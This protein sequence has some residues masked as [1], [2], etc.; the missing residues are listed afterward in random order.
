MF[1]TH[2]TN[3][4]SLTS[5]GEGIV[6]LDGYK[7]FIEGALPQEEILFE[8][9]DKKRNFARGKLLEIKKTSPHRV[10]PPCPLF[11]Q[12]GGCQI[13]HLAY[14]KQ[15]EVKRNRVKESLERI[16][17]FENVA[18]NSCI[19][20]PQ[21]FHYRNKIQLPIHEK[22][23]GLFRKGTHE[24]IPLKK[25]HIHNTQGEAIL[26]RIEPFLTKNSLRYIIIKSTSEGS[27]IILVTDGSQSCEISKIAQRIYNQ[28]PH[29]T[30]IIEMVNKSDN[31]VILSSDFKSLVGSP[32]IFE[33]IF[34]KRFR[35]SASSFFQV[36]TLQASHLISFVMQNAKLKKN[37]I[38][39]DAYCGVG[40]FSLFVS[41][42]VSKVMGT[43]VSLSSIEDAKEN[44]LINKRA[45]AFFYQ[46]NAENLIP[47][48]PPFDVA[49]LNPPRKGCEKKLI[50]ELLKRKIRTIVYISCDPATL[51]R[52]LSLL[53]AGNKYVLDS[54][55]PFD[56]FPQTMHVETAVILTQQ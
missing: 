10:K 35:V 39:L 48:L 33:K 18:V 31:N 27:L 25:C 21:P 52:D 15:L 22:K 53:C 16:G 40:T 14:E 8:I 42:I 12:C 43:E 5:E 56:M 54:I 1:E 3:V 7:V 50:Q 26:S 49:L 44:A 19:P 51:A 30:G 9:V 29:I 45:N 28:M 6:S 20:S 36:N 41:D 32:Y 23:I 11:G 55:Q 46:G 24:I 38:F 17:N 13:M 2:F 37:D 47:H 34:D 4:I